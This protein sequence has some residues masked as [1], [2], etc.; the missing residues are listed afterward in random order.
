VK[1]KI[2]IKLSRLKILAICFLLIAGIIYYYEEIKQTNI[3]IK[4]TDVI[5]VVSDIPENEIITKDMIIA[6]KR[7]AEDVMKYENIATTEDAVIG[8]RAI[9]PLYKG[10]PINN[11]RLLVNKEYMNKRDQTQIAIDLT[12]IDKA[13]ELKAGDYIDIWLEPVSQNQDQIV[14]EPYKFIQKI[15][16][17]EIHDSSYNNIEKGKKT[18]LEDSITTADSVYIPAYITIEL[19]DDALKEM[20]SVDK[21]LYTIRVTRYGEEKFYSVVK[22]VIKGVE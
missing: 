1:S 22:N 20:Y 9:V 3:E 13:L 19:S 4:T 6:E 14:I 12:E 17:I 2:L 18:V 5:V 21:N 7:Y 10:E 8:K 16:I 11:D 15:Q